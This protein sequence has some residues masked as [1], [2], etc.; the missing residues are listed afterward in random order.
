[1]LAKIALGMFVTVAAC[2]AY[3]LQDGFVHVTVEEFQKD[4]THLH[5]LVPAALAPLGAHLIPQR[6][7]ARSRE[8]LSPWLPA[9]RL[10]ASEL[11]KLPDSVLVEVR[12]DDE[13][14]RVAKV[15][16]GLEVEEESP[17]EHV[18]VW[19]PLRAIYDMADSFEARFHSD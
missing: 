4:G 2:T 13:H 8:R 3:L 17:R 10:T 18:H 5:L 11:E 19:V 12:D 14:V 15:G 9:L 6:E 16:D 1:M 7:L